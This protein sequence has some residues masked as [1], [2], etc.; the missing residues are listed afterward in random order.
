VLKTR[1][2]LHGDDTRPNAP[3]TKVMTTNS[4]PESRAA[5]EPMMT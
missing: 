4:K 5:A 1:I 3:E 2:P